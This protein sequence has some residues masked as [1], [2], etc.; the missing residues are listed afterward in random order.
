MC[1]IANTFAFNCKMFKI[2]NWFSF[3]Q[4]KIIGSYIFLHYA[5]IIHRTWCLTFF[6]FL[7]VP[8]PVFLIAFDIVSSDRN[9][10]IK[11]N[12]S[13]HT[14]IIIRIL[15]L[16]SKMFY[17]IVKCEWHCLLDMTN[18]HDLP[19]IVIKLYHFLNMWYLFSFWFGHVTLNRAY[20]ASE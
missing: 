12:Q 15:K 20:N 2:V 5:R 18:R 17:N 7:I 1:L 4:T 9:W 19:L 14:W 3:I 16:S 6:T 10:I 8:T 13:I 11:W